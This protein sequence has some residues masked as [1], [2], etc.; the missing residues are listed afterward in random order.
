MFEFQTLFKNS[1]EKKNGRHFEV[2]IKVLRFK[3]CREQVSDS[4]SSLGSSTNSSYIFSQKFP[5]FLGLLKSS[6]ILVLLL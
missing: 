4:V 6:G 3:A 1:L 2:L 5:C